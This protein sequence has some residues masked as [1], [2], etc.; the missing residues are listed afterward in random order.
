MK[1]DQ[2]IITGFTPQ[3]RVVRSATIADL[4]GLVNLEE[5][6]FS[7]PW[8]RK[9]FEA[10]LNG[11]QFSKILVVPGSGKEPE[12][13]L[14]AYICVWV[15]FEEIRFLNLAVH[16][17]FRRQGLGKELI[18]EAIRIGSNQGC[19][20][21]MLEVRHSNH[22]AKTLYE[23]L[24]FKEYATRKSYYTNPTEDAILMMLEPVS[25]AIS[26]RKN[27]QGLQ[28]KRE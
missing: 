22:M 3:K 27:L 5:V 7:V 12:I 13:P 19:C 4:N 18:L 15:I 9:S 6:C 10:E 11:N 23:S 16:P 26:D 17:Q 20:R 28:V 25:K 21:G 14:L 1:I 24:Y 2:S 8:S